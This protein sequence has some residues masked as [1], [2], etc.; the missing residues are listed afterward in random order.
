MMEEIDLDAFLCNIYKAVLLQNNEISILA[1]NL[2]NIVDRQPIN[3]EVESFIQNRRNGLWKKFSGL[4]EGEEGCTALKTNIENITLGTSNFLDAQDGDITAAKNINLLDFRQFSQKLQYSYIELDKILE[5]QCGEAFKVVHDYNKCNELI[6]AINTIYTKSE[7]ESARVFHRAYLEV[8]DAT[9]SVNVAGD[10][11]VAS[12]LNTTVYEKLYKVKFKPGCENR[13]RNL[14]LDSKM[15]Y[16]FVLHN[17]GYLVSFRITCSGTSATKSN[18]VNTIEA[19]V[20]HKEITCDTF[21]LASDMHEDFNMPEDLIIITAE[22]TTITK[23]SLN[24]SSKEIT[25]V[26]SS[27]LV[28][29]KGMTVSSLFANSELVIVGC[30]SPDCSIRVVSLETLARLYKIDHYNSESPILYAGIITSNNWSSIV[31]AGSDKRFRQFN[32]YKGK[33]YQSTGGV[34]PISISQIAKRISA[35]IKKYHMEDVD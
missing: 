16:V 12:K 34:F 25:L 4:I 28:G 17:E 26:K 15:E 24:R 10:L 19:T 18:K 31:V 1:R 11:K 8:G 32:Y 29:R 20:D 21:C 30:T 2:Q 3:P 13:Y 33:W 23:Y 27:V 14:E 6:T 5:K 7:L 35:S 22:D 9:F